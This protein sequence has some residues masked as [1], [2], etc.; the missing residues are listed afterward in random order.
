MLGGPF[1]YFEHSHKV[2][3]INSPH[4]KTRFLQRSLFLFLHFVADMTVH[5]Q[6]GAG[7]QSPGGALAST[8]IADLA[9]RS[10]VTNC[11]MTLSTEC[12]KITLN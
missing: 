7:F 6:V 2:A 4:F 5:F 3:R 10:V 1:K 12:M 8:S 11:E 9:S